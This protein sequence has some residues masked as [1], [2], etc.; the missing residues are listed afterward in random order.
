MTYALSGPLQEAI[1][2]HL[3][4]DAAI[5]AAVGAH[6]YDAVP[7]GE[8][9]A[10]YVTLGP[11]DVRDRS[12]GSAA[13]AE[14]RI[15]ISVVTDAAGFCDAKLLAGHVADALENAD[16]TLNRGRLVGIWFERASAR[17][18]GKAGRIRRIDL[19][20]RARVEDV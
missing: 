15:E 8:L 4:A 6:V 11:E 18:T 12:D 10:T 19:K 20:F 1:Y 9:P 17:R 16:L 7:P 13:G 3:V 2:Q 14:H 5:S